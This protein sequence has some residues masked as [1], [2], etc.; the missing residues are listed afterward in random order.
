M[1]KRNSRK[2]GVGLLLYCKH[3]NFVILKRIRPYKCSNIDYDKNNG[4]Y[5]EQFQ[6]PRGSL[7]A[8]EGEFDGARREFREETGI[9]PLLCQR[10]HTFYLWFT[11]N[12]DT[13]RYVIFLCKGTG[14]IEKNPEYLY[15]R[16]IVPKEK[17]IHIL[18]KQCQLYTTSN[19]NDLIVFIESS[20]ALI[21]NSTTN[22]D[23]VSNPCKC[24]RPLRWR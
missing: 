10:V 20:T 8:N 19:Y 24:F 15:E 17:M 2:I 23:N 16:I 4:S 3:N 5:P 14:I 11:D 22:T 9:V 7:H 21:D 1:M 18:D 12:S 6:I 13:Y